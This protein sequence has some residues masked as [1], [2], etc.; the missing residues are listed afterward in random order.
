MTFSVISIASEPILAFA[1]LLLIILFVP[2]VFQKINLPGIVGLLLAGTIV[3][4]KGFGLIEAAGVI[5]VLGKVG[6]LYLMF[7]AGLEINLDQFKKEKKNTFVFGA[8]TFLIPQTLGTLIFYWMGY[9]LPASLLIAS[10]FAS[11]TLVAYPIISRLGLMKEKSVS[12]A[13]GGTIITDTVALLVLAVVARSVEG[14]LDM[15]FWVTLTGLFSIYLAFMFIVLPKASFRFFQYVG[16]KGRFTYV[17]V[18][19]M[20]L[21]AAWLAE[22]I[23][24]EAIVGAFLAGLSFNR[25]LSNKGPLKNRVEFFG[26]AFFIPLFLIFVGMQVDIA[27]LTGSTD[28]WIIMGVMTATVVITKWMAAFASAK[29]LNFSNDQAWVIFGLTNSQAAATLAAVFVGMEVGLIG[30]EVLNGAIMMI[31]VTCIIGPIVVEKFGHKLTDDIS[32]GSDAK[33]K[34]NQRIMVPISNPVTS[35][36]LIEFAANLRIKGSNPIYPLSVINTYVDAASQRERAQKIL[37]TASHHIHA[38]NSAANPVIETNLNIAEGI[39]LAAEKHAITDIVIGWNGEITTP[40]KVFGS[41]VDQLIQTSNQQI[42][43][44]KFDQPISTFEKIRLVIPPKKAVGKTFLHLFGNIVRLAENLNTPLEIYHLSE[45]EDQI[46]HNVDLLSPS[47][48]IKFEKFEKFDL[49][50]THV[51]QDLQ[52]SDLLIVTNKRS[53]TYGWAYGTN[54]VP[55]TMASDKPGISFIIVYP[56]SAEPV[57]YSTNLIYTS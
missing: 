32:D 24:I 1:I 49:L 33:P 18:I 7:L 5:D 12:A 10:M 51:L 46:S 29:I 14:D 27:V 25:L 57:D 45:D 38:V 31:L 35:D 40:M 21:I 55:R 36:R 11:H 26:D 8:L 54:L 30:E 28:V 44:C 15:M 34:V 22:V 53:G 48:D 41:V 6:L 4:P 16:E 52:N 39:H 42:F 3:G 9:S 23:G 50:M 2:L 13:V 19:G 43:V 56:H 37:D 17:Y 20:M 47:L